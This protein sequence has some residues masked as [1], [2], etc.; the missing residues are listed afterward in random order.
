MGTSL[1]RRYGLKAA[2]AKPDE[3]K[4]ELSAQPETL[5]V[6]V[7]RELWGGSKERNFRALACC[8]SGPGFGG[9]FT[10]AVRQASSHRCRRS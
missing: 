5:V 7:D 9:A 3:L 6:E 1:I 8:Y 4:A 10:G 2:A